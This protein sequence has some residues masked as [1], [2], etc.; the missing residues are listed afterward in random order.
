MNKIFHPAVITRFSMGDYE[1][2]LNDT[3]MGPIDGASWIDSKKRYHKTYAVK[4]R[5]GTFLRRLYPDK[6]RREYIEYV[7]NIDKIHKYNET[8]N[9]RTL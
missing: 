9:K 8:K 4:N 3:C 2:L 1:N 6:F 7:K 5:Y